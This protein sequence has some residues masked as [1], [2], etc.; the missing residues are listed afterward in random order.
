MAT[1]LFEQIASLFLCLCA[2]F[3]LVKLGLLHS[4]DSRIL[5]LV[6][7]YLIFPC[8]YI[9]AFQLPLTDEI[10][11]GFLFALVVGAVIQLILILVTRWIAKPLHL[12]PID[13]ASIVFSNAANLNFPLIAAILG[14]EWVIYGSAYVFVHT[15]LYWTVC[16]S[17]ISGQSIRNWKKVLL[18]NNI[19]FILIASL[20]MITG[21]PIPRI[22]NTTINSV[23]AMI[24]P[25]SMILVGIILGGIDLRRALLNRRV[26][27]VAFLKLI[28]VPALVLLLMRL[29]RLPELVVNGDKIVYIL[30][31]AVIAPTGVLVTQIAQLYHQ[32]AEYA[33]AIN[34]VTTLLCIATMP[35][36]TW[37]YFLK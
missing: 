25:L 36:M 5:N 20:L 16:V 21:L 2:G 33:S 35:L 24:G 8:V 4:S 31:L 7:V 12:N 3:L 11:S 30:F 15:I 29:C 1:L 22:L 13:R 10:R 27:L 14:D 28:A 34:V 26:Y 23:A 18:N 19:I 32:D 37:I 6:C 9:K 17:M